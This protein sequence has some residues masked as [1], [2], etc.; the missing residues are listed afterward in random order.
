M[1]KFHLKPKIL[2]SLFILVVAACAF[3]ANESDPEDKADPS[4]TIILQ[5]YLRASQDHEDALR[6]ASMKV[7][8]DAAIPSLKQHGRLSLLRKISKVGQITYHQL[9]F[10]GDASVKKDVIVRYLQAEQQG[11]GDHSLAITP[12]NYKFK[13]KGLRP[14]PAGKAV[15]MF[16]VSPR[17]KK[18]GLFKGW[19]WLD[20]KTCLPIVEKGRWVKNPSIFLKQVDFE[21]KFTVTNGI[22]VPEH[23]SGTLNVRLVGKVE[24]NIDYSDFQPDAAPDANTTQSASSGAARVD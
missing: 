14:I 23:M 11:Q 4:S 8:I 13:Y 2:A 1:S 17:Q 3:A 5:K 21:R 6:G 22:S 7:D 16:Q 18:V 20:E 9:G 10:E 12:A 24:L 15:Y 19:L